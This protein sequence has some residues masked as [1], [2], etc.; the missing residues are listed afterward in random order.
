MSAKKKSPFHRTISTYSL[1]ND[2]GG[3]PYILEHPPSYVGAV[4]RNRIFYYSIVS[5]RKS[6]VQ[7]L[8]DGF[9][10][11]ECGIGAALIAAGTLEG[12]ILNF[13][14]ELNLRFGA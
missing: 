8:L 11:L 2:K 4:G 14:I 6:E 7:T 9:N 3:R 10:L 5:F 1:N 13:T 12:R